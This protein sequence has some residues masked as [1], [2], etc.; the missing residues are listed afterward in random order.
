M[1]TGYGHNISYVGWGIYR[2]HWHYDSKI[3]GSR[4]RWPQSRSRDTDHA[5]AVRFSKK[6][7]CDVPTV[8]PMSGWRR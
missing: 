6:W 2:L 7:G 1:S 4:L 5:G 3:K 8:T